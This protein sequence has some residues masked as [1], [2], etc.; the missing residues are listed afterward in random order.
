LKSRFIIEKCN[1]V[2]VIENKKMKAM[3]EELKRSGYDPDPVAVW[4]MKQNKDEAL[5]ST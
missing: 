2:L 5:V 1:G 4:K 3:V